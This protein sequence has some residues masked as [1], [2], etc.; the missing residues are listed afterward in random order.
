MYISNI[1]NLFL[2]FW[3]SEFTWVVNEIAFI[4]NAIYHLN[5][6]PPWNQDYQDV[7]H[8]LE[9]V[10]ELQEKL[11]INSTPHSVGHVC[12]SKFLFW[13]FLP[14]RSR[15]S[16]WEGLSL[17]D[18]FLENFFSEGSFSEDSFLE[19][20]NS[21]LLLEDFFF[22]DLRSRGLFWG[23]SISGFFR[24]V[25]SGKIWDREVRSE[26]VCSWEILWGCFCRVSSW[27]I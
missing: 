27:E 7:F 24:W 4:N 12:V 5:F 2:S 22:G 3:F 26:E 20:S 25:F 14:G 18:S 1:L 6:T 9:L 21:K 17:R 8:D 23:D 15:D 19:D 10:C 11:G 13:T 16:L